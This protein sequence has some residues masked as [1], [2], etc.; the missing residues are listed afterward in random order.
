MPFCEAENG[1]RTKQMTNPVVMGSP[2]AR[3]PARPPPQRGPACSHGTYEDVFT[4]C[5][6]VSRFVC[7]ARVAATYIIARHARRRRPRACGSCQLPAAGTGDV[8]DDRAVSMYVYARCPIAENVTH[9]SKSSGR[10][11]G[12]RVVQCVP[13]P[14]LRPPGTR[15][16]TSE[17]ERSITPQTLL[18][19]NVL[20]RSQYWW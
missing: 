5:A 13:R 3:H 11:G 10:G 4:L 8:L 6:S 1:R 20:A 15:C 9:L 12:R 14:R 18:S 2:C 16:R 7:F 17:V 19:L